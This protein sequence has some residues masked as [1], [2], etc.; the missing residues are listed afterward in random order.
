MPLYRRLP[1]RGFKIKKSEKVAILNL[2]KLQ[3]LMSK[4]KIQLND[5]INLENL[6]KS[7]LVSSKYDK[8]KI[9][10]FGDIKNKI[11]I[12]S[13]YISKPAKEKIEK[14]GGSVKLIN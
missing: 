10:G 13:N 14:V 2:Y 4:K 3:D 1:K 12:E 7:K 5:K 9:L 8:L 6:K 11:E